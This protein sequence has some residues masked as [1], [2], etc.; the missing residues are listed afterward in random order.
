MPFYLL[1]FR[2]HTSEFTLMDTFFTIVKPQLDDNPNILNYA[3]VVEKDGTV[4]RHVHSLVEF[5]ETKS[6]NNPLKQFYNKNIFKQFNQMMK[7][8]L[9][10]VK[11][12]KD[13]RKLKDTQEDFLYTLG[14]VL[15]EVGANR[16]FYTFSEEQ[17]V[18]AIDYYYQTQK[19]D[20]SQP[21]E[22][23]LKIMTPKNI[24]SSIYD[25]CKKKEIKK[26]KYPEYL[27]TQ[28][29]KEGY[30]F[31]QVNKVQESMTEL[32]VFMNPDDYQDDEDTDTITTYHELQ[33]KVSQQD[34]L[35]KT[36]QKQLKQIYYAT[37]DHTHL[38]HINKMTE[39]QY[40]FS[41]D[42]DDDA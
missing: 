18:K 23:D 31:S 29:R 16:R 15:K 37:K 12:A 14:Y 1:T 13:D 30:M 7:N 3:I 24:H 32:D 27:R 26:I 21:E 42:S 17:C 41:D 40:Y 25:F 35:I 11:W 19:I 38:Q 9:T 10:N 39:Y 20:K 6:K 33:E 28:M 5:K 2:P 4:N 22:N 8:I 36:L 34:D